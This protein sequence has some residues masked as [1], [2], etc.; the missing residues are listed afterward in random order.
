VLRIADSSAAR[1]GVGA[2]LLALLLALRLLSPAGF[3]PAFDRGAVTIV[4]CPDAEPAAAGMAGHHHHKSKQPH[5]PCPYA[6]ASALGWLANDLPLLAGVLVVGLALL[7][8]RPFAFLER[9]RTRERPPLRG[10][11]LPA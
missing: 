8:G 1:R 9:H 6:A 4:I 7:V 2:T 11:P 3:M 10:P 5:Q